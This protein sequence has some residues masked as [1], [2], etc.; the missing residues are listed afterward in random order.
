MQVAA[1]L[2][3]GGIGELRRQGDLGVRQRRAAIAVAHVHVRPSIEEQLHAG[4][5]AMVASKVCWR[6]EALVDG[7]DEG[8]RPQQLAHTIELVVS[9]V[10]RCNVQR[11]AV[12]V[13]LRIQQVSSR[14]DQDVQTRERASAAGGMQRRIIFGISLVERTDGVPACRVD[15]ASQRCRVST[16]RRGDGGR[17]VVGCRHLCLGVCRGVRPEC[18]FCFSLADR[19]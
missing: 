18:M 6:P 11:R 19:R 17:V 13:V 15:D 5:L 12:Q 7:V 16:R 8:T 4:V 9:G 2:G 1:L 14:R 10:D 3:V